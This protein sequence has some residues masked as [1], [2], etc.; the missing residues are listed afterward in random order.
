[1]SGKTGNE[2]AQVAAFILAVIVTS[3]LGFAFLFGDIFEESKDGIIL[4]NK[5]NPNKADAI[6]LQRLPGIGAGR[7][8]AIVRYREQ[9]R[10]NA[11]EQV[12]RC[13]E[14]LDEVEGIG[15][16]TINNISNWLTF[17]N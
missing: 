13:S 5:I 10:Q 14:D 3:A 7:A 1:M 15:V 16:K 9:K 17:E 8:E 6:S 12:F 4:Q 2:N 11:M